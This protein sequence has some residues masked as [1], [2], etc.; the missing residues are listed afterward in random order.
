MT[1]ISGHVSLNFPL[2]S[3]CKSKDKYRERSVAVI[4]RSHQMIGKERER[5]R[6]REQP[7]NLLWSFGRRTDSEL[8]LAYQSEAILVT[9]EITAVGERERGKRRRKEWGWGLS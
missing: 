9:F 7:Q 3:I 8:A 4:S 1:V 6:V 2:Y 5:E